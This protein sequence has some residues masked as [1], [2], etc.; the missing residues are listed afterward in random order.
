VRCGQRSRRETVR[1]GSARAWI[2]LLLLPCR[3]VVGI[4]L[5]AWK[6]LWR[7]DFGGRSIG[8]CQGCGGRDASKRRGLRA[9]DDPVP[10]GRCVMA[11][12]RVMDWR[13]GPTP[14]PWEPLRVAIP[15][16]VAFDLELFQ[17]TVANLAREL[18]CEPCLS[19]ASCRFDLIRDYVVSPE[20]EPVPVQV[21]GAAGAVARA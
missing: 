20:G 13:F 12:E 14:H 19:G 5:N 3:V 2:V 16:R 6:A 7:L 8:G 17:K 9:G 11:A 21:V 4:R 10:E 15:A 18:G 1:S